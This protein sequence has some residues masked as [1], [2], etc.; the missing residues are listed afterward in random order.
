[1]FFIKNCFKI[2]IP[3]LKYNRQFS[4][5]NNRCDFDIDTKKKIQLTFA[6]SPSLYVLS[7][8]NCVLTIVSIFS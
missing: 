7:I 1:M 2:K 5:C 8:S 3:T 4:N 6:M